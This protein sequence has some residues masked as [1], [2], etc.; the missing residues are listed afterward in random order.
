MDFKM[1]LM[2]KPPGAASREVPLQKIELLWDDEANK[3]DN[4]WKKNHRRRT[5]PVKTIPAVDESSHPIW[6]D[7]SNSHKVL[8]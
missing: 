4:I 5:R 8:K 6:N 3:D 1:Y 2:F 7:S